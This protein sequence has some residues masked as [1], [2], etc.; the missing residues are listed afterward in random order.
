MKKEDLL[1]LKEKLSKLN[2]HEKKL[3]DLYLRKIANGELQGPMVGYPSIDNPSLKYRDEESITDRPNIVNV[4]KDLYD[5]NI[6]YLDQVALM[7]FGA[8]ITFKELFKRIDDTA[9]AL[10][11]ND[12]K[13]GDFITICA[14][15]TPEVV[16]MFYALAKIGAVANF[17]SPFFDKKQMMER[18]SDCNSKI[19]VVMDNFY[20]NI[21]ETIANSNIEKTIL[22][23]TL[24]A[25]P[26]GLVKKS[27]KPSRK[28][29]IMWN[30]FIKEGK[31]V[32]IPKLVDYEKEMP[33]AMVYSSG[34]TGA[35]KAILLTHDSFGN[36]AFAYPRCN[37]GLTRGEKYYQIIPPWFS[38]GISTSTHLTLVQGGTL[39][40]DP[41]F[42]RK[43]FVENMLKQ[44]PAGTIASITLFQA[45]L[46]DELLV[47]GS[48][49]NLT[50][51]FQGG[52]KMEMQDKE[53]IEKVFKKYNSN[54]RLMNGYGQ[55]ECGAGITTQTP[56]TPSNTTVGIPIPGVK[57]GI[58]D[59][60]NNELPYNT[61][62][63]IYACTPCGMK[64]Y[65]N[66]PQATKDYFY[67]EFGEKWSK[68]GDIGSINE[69]GELEI[70]G[71]AG[72]F[73]IINGKKIYNFDIEASILKNPVIQN[74]DVFSDDE[75]VLVAHIILK[76][77]SENINKLE[78]IKLLQQAIYMDNS[79]IDYVPCKFKFRDSF[80][81]ANFSKKDVAG[82]K[83]EKDGFIIVDKS[84]LVH[85]K[86]LV[87]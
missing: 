9:K 41:R 39:F 53:N 59:E 55:C 76:N 2:E 23:P 4:Y 75:G 11:A 18:I 26:L 37:V 35:S 50:R 64:E 13:K 84:Y 51:T 38:T 83:K 68:T 45:F 61:K 46:D 27:I 20:P 34:T 16:Y 71:R 80:P 48:L 69:N 74:C 47:S 21:G 86:K 67:Y 82:M 44:N 60:D 63:E 85:V 52:E 65:Y 17:M 32:D 72:D 7:Y 70:F 12:V 87:K 14:A 49:S 31:H 19:A 42:D 24:N 1:L 62:G 54:S 6:D 56:L 10:V 77:S 36:T 29:E 22:L 79:D 66:N 8:K 57:I 25:S 15:L 28:N 58:F 73:E 43:V 40:M 78:L 5:K 30:E 3:R 81:I 33:L